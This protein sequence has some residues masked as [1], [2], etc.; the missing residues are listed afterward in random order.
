M[1]KV[2][3]YTLGKWSDGDGEGVPILDSVTG[4]H[5]TNVTTEGLD[6]PNILQYGRDHGNTLRKMTFQQRGL[7]LK[8]L[9][10]YLTKRRFLRVELSNRCHQ[11]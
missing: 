4:A 10:L 6:I 5:F 11:S 3:H 7:M 8:K 9:A 1:K 2:Q